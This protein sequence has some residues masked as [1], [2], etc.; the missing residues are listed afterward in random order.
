MKSW[1]ATST[2]PSTGWRSPSS[3][4]E[5]NA[6]DRPRGGCAWLSMAVHDQTDRAEASCDFPLTLAAR[7]AFSGQA[8]HRHKPSNSVPAEQRACTIDQWLAAPPRVPTNCTAR[9]TRADASPQFRIPQS[10]K[11]PIVTYFFCPHCNLIKLTSLRQQPLSPT[12]LASL[13][14]KSGADRSLLSEKYLAG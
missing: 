13:R 12:R 7:G 8:W 2:S 1:R 11:S 9:S 5:V 10:R 4:P 3:W 6:N 14:Q